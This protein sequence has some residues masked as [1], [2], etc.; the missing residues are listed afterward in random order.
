MTW[1]Y[2]CP[3]S[4]R[5]KMPRGALKQDPQDEYDTGKFEETHDGCGAV[6]C[7]TVKLCK[8]ASSN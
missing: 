5:L 6:L 3:Y 8:Q 4:A 2:L 1:R 7:E